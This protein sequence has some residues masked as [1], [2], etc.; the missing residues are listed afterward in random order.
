MRRIHFPVLLRNMGRDEA[1]T[2]VTL[3]TLE[4]LSRALLI[5]IVPLEAYRLLGSAFWVSIVYFAASGLGLLISIFLP[6]IIHT[7]TRRWALTVAMATGQLLTCERRTS[8]R[9]CELSHNGSFGGKKSETASPPKCPM[10]Q[11][12][13]SGPT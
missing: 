5:T 2:F 11:E 4:A 3:F 12:P 7:I 1:G 8:P 9:R 6:T 13:A 10:S